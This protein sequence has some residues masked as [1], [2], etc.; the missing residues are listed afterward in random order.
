MFKFYTAGHIILVLAGV[1]TV[2][3]AYSFYKLRRRTNNSQKKAIDVSDVL[4]KHF[5]TSKKQR[6]RIGV[7]TVNVNN[8]TPRDKSWKQ[9]DENDCPRSSKNRLI[10][11]KRHDEED[12]TRLVA[13]PRVGLLDEINM[14]NLP[15]CFSELVRNRVASLDAVE[16]G[17]D[18][19]GI[20]AVDFHDELLRLVENAEDTERSMLLAILSRLGSELFDNGFELIKLLEWDPELQNAVV[21]THGGNSGGVKVI[22]TISSGVKRNDRILRKQEVSILTSTKES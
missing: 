13:R 22:D 19:W 21:V 18:E 15:S 8:T 7:G 1:A 3:G 9:T 17:K 14:T 16:Y 11:D 4:E 10:I 12:V 20:K 2:V 5:G 6:S